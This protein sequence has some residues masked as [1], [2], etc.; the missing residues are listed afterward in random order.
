MTT[1]TKNTAA[2]TIKNRFTRIDGRTYDLPYS[3]V[4]AAFP[5]KFPEGLEVKAAITN[6][7]DAAR[8]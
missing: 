1:A 6:A 2:L 7:V 4:A 3:K 5:V 8:L